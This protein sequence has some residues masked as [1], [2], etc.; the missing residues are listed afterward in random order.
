M[1]MTR[2][3]IAAVLI[4]TAFAI[5]ASAADCVHVDIVWRDGSPF[6][7]TYTGDVHSGD[8]QVGVVGHYFWVN[9]GPAPEGGDEGNGATSVDLSDPTITGVSVCGETVSLERQAAEVEV[10]LPDPKETE[11]SPEPEP[12]ALPERETVTAP[13]FPPTACRRTALEKV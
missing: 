7:G 6:A 4:S 3:L 5:P 2:K 10:S 12:V 11:P 13:A 9:Y 8:L 1:T